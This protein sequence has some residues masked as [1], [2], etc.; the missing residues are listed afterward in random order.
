MSNYKTIL[1]RADASSTIGTGHIMRDLV[2]AKQY[3]NDKIYFATRDLEGNLNDKIK[4]SGYE[5]IT[6][7]S[8]DIDKLDKI[9]KKLDID[10]LIIDHYEIDYDFEKKLKTQN[11]KLK[12][13]SFDDTYEKHYCDIL[14]NHNI[15]ADKERYRGLVPEFCELRCGE[16]YTL[17]R[18]EFYKAKK[19]LKTQNSKLKIFLAMGGSDSANLNI[20]ILEILK[21]FENLNVDVVT[22]TANQKLKELESYCKD[23]KWVKLHV[24]SKTIAKLM[25]E[26]DFG[27]ITPSVTANEAYF[28][29]LAFIAIKT[30]HNQKEMVEFLK[31][32]RYGVFSDLTLLK[33]YLK[34]ILR[35]Q[36][37]NFSS[38]LLSEQKMILKWRNNPSVRKW[39]FNQD[40][41]DLENHIKYISSLKDNKDK[42]YFL[43]KQFSNYL[44]VIDFTQITT[45]SAYIGLYS[46]PDLK[47]V[48]AILM[49]NII[50]YGFGKL[51]VENLLSEVF[52]D[53]QKAISLYKKFNF[54]EID[55]KLV[56]NREVIL[57]ELNNENR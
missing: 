21:E 47:S 34:S 28:M 11:S 30:A 52:S 27:I 7:K 3:P 32:N 4:E 31:M 13:L 24:N 40:I 51:N 15:Y 41:I 25:R 19:Q 16:K 8:N 22:T 5:V 49:K 12:I 50:E 35:I 56:D 26:S 44:G 37:K 55:R 53:N 46:N 43:V 29:K 9:I 54:K 39:M 33:K 23:K 1:F 38:L 36:L 57:M 14:L 18:E 2:L 45:K 17:L 42:I 6:L 10:L 20:P 48:G